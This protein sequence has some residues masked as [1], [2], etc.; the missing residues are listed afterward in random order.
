[1]RDIGKNI[2]RAREQKGYGQE[3]LAELLFV[4]RQTVSNYETGRS[5]PDVDTLVKLAGLL[6][7][8]VTALI[9]GAEPRKTENRRALWLRIGASVV[10]IC[11]NIWLTAFAADYARKYYSELPN[12]IRLMVLLPCLWFELGQLAVE[13]LRLVWK[14]KPV[15][16]AMGIR[17]A[18]AVWIVFYTVC[19]IPVLIALCTPAF[20]IPQWLGRIA[21]TVVGGGAGIPKTL[22]LSLFFL[23]GAGLA[24]T[25]TRSW[26]TK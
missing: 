24:L 23:S 17:I 11:L 3:Q 19:T 8:E 14:A 10:L 22:Y 15:P 16:F 1:M 5:R 21:L 25:E 7:V 2:R 18:C 26:E 6:D 20:V 12:G 13:L 4:T 9:Y